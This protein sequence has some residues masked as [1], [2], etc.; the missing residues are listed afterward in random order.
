MMVVWDDWTGTQECHSNLTNNIEFS[1]VYY[2]GGGG[3]GVVGR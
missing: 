1:V 3:G 2:D